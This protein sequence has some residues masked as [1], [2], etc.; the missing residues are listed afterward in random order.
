LW[1]PFLDRVPRGRLRG[2]TG[3]ERVTSLKPRELHM[4]L[5]GPEGC[6]EPNRSILDPRLV[7]PT[8]FPTSTAGGRE[9]QEI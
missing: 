9:A 5:R 8:S 4:I 3:H 6:Q 2:K 1:G 7:W